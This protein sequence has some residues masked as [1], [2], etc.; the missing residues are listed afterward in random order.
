MSEFMPATRVPLPGTDI[1]EAKDRGE[2]IH[3][4]VRGSMIYLLH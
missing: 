2:F 1:Q 3:G 4:I